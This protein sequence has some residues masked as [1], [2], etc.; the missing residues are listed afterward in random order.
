MR[1]LICGSRTWIDKAAIAADLFELGPFE[2][3][4]HGGARGADRISGE[5]ARNLG[6]PVKV[7]KA[8]WRRYGKRAGSI[9]NLEML[10]KGKPDLVIAYWDGESPGTRDMILKAER[11]GVTVK[12]VVDKG[13]S[14]ASRS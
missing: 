11:A 9:R 10:D 13:E 7:Y 2:V 12:M 5:V 8:D 14:C 3:V 6:I 1:V 4:I